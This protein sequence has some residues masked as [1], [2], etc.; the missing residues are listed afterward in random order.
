MGI[1]NVSVSIDN[2]EEELARSWNL[3]RLHHGD[4]LTVFSPGMFIYNGVRGKYQAVSI[5]GSSCSLGC[6]H[7]KG[8]LLET[9]PKAQTPESLLE[10][11][12]EAQKRGDTGILL[13]GACDN[14]GFL[15]WERF[16]DTIAEVKSRTD[17]RVSIHPG[18]LDEKAARI[19][20]SAGV[21]QA[22]VD[23][24]GSDNT[25]H[26]VYHLNGGVSSI[27]RTMDALS[28]VAIEMVPHIIVGLHF[29][30]I[31]GEYQALEIIKGYPV[32]KYVVVV[33]NPLKRT[34]MEKVVP[35][36]PYEVGRF[37]V[38]ARLEMPQTM[39]S[40]GCARPGGKYRG[41]VD[42]IAVKAGV[43]SIA[44]AS[45]KALATAEKMGL[46]IRYEGSCCS[47]N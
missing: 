11:A 1:E 29:G 33:L 41:Q 31:V 44:L 2:F 7:C 42:T 18:Q 14:D 36:A 21:D 5:T 27:V 46:K 45:D 26:D 30:E 15:P 32:R 17:L 37:L 20:K 12:L 13:T 39:A 38:R 24:I 3:S 40:L 4:I 47:V 9:M 34:P 10:F 25:A 19:L 28:D 22:L 6:E 16:A 8:L 43:N 35:P 23:V